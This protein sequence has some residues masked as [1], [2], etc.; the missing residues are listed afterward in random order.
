MN[1]YEFKTR[2][3]YGSEALHKLLWKA[4]CAILPLHTYRSL[5]LLQKKKITL[6]LIGSILS[7][8]V[9]LCEQ[10]FQK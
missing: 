2:Y 7:W 6:E 4:V 9:I 10:K 5:L 1:T 8:V 3:N